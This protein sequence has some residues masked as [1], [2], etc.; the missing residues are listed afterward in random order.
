[1]VPKYVHQAIE[2]ILQK[3]IY[4]FIKSRYAKINKLIINIDK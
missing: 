2:C 4:L 3:F 1:M